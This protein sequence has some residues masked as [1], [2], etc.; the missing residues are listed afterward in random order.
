MPN[1]EMRKYVIEIVKLQLHLGP[2]RGVLLPV[3]AFLFGCS[4]FMASDLR[5][6]LAPGVDGST[7]KN[8]SKRPCVDVVRVF[9]IFLQPE[10]I[11]SSL[12]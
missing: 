9:K 4:F 3:L 2:R 6:L 1:T 12:N 8:P 5:L 11:R 10:R 7:L